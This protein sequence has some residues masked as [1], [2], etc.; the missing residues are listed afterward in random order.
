MDEW[1]VLG[2]IP[3]VQALCSDIIS[4]DLSW[5][6]TVH[7]FFNRVQLKFHMV[8]GNGKIPLTLWADFFFRILLGRVSPTK[9]K[10]KSIN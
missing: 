4:S 1:I 5:A 9:E 2:N 6:S 3:Q 7:S 8:I 10:E